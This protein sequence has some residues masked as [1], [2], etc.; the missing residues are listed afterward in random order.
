MGKYLDYN[1][2][3]YLWRKIKAFFVS[4]IGVSGNDLTYTKNG[5]TNNITIPYAT[6]AGALAILQSKT[7][8]NV[9]GTADNNPGSVFYFL[10]VKPTDW[11]LP[12]IVTYRIS[13]KIGGV[14]SGTAVSILKVAFTRNTM[15][16]YGVW[17]YIG[18]TNYR[19]YYYHYRYL[20]TATGFNAG[21]GHLLGIGLNSSYKPTTAANARTFDVEVLEIS[22][23]TFTLF[24]SMTKYANV[25]GTGSTNYSGETTLNATTQG[26]THSGDATATNYLHSTG[27]VGPVGPIGILSGSLFMQTGTGHW[28][29]FTTNNSASTSSNKQKNTEGFKLESPVL[30][31]TGTNNAPNA[32]NTNV[33]IYLS[34][35]VDLRYSTNCGATL[36]LHRPVYL[37]GTI[38]SDGLFYLDDTWWTQTLPSSDDGKVYI[39]LGQ[40]YGSYTIQL[41]PMHPIYYFKNGKVRQYLVEQET[42]P[43]FSASP[44]AG[45]TSADITSWNGK[46]DTITDL[47]TIRSGA[48]AG[49]TAYQ[50]PSGGIPKSDLSSAVQTSL[51]KADTALQSHQDISGKVDKVTSTDNA[52]VRFNGTSG[53]IQNSGV[54]IDDNNNVT[55]AKFV[56]KNGTN[57]QFVKGDGSLSDYIFQLN[58]SFEA[59]KQMLYISPLQNALWAADKRFVVTCVDI[60]GNG[61]ETPITSNLNELFNFNYEDNSNRIAAGHTYKIT[62]SHSSPDSAYMF[63]YSSGAFIVNFYYTQIPQSVSLRLYYGEIGNI[64]W[65]NSIAVD[66]ITGISSGTYKCWISEQYNYVRKIEI[67]IVARANGATWPN[68]LEYFQR[69][70]TGAASMPLVTK[71]SSNTLL[72]NLTAPKFIKTGGTSSQFLKADGSVDSNTY[73]KTSDI[74]AWAK[75]S[76]KPS[77]TWNEINDKPSTFTPS[78]HTHT[79]SIATST[80]TNQITLAHGSKYSITAGGTSYIFTMPAS[81]NTDRYVNSAAFA[82]DSTNTA[83]SPVKMTLTRAGSDTATVTANIPK[84]SS[85]SA[86]VAPKGAAVSSQSQSTK[87]LREDGTWAAPSYTTNTNTT[88]SFTGGTNGRFSVTPSGSNTQTVAVTKSFG[89]SIEYIVGTQTAATNLWIGVTQEASLSAGKMIAYKLPVAGNGSAATLNLTLSGGGTTGAIGVRRKGTGTVTT[90]YSAGEIIFMVYDGSYWQIN[91]YYDSDSTGYYTK[92]IYPN[93]KAGPGKI[94]PYTMIMQLPDGRWESLV[95]SNST[96]TSKVA[97]THGFLLG[98]VLLM[99]ANAT[100]TE[101]QNVGTYYIWSFH[102]GLIDHRYSFNT[103]NDSTNGTTGYKPIYIVGSIGSDGLF[104]LDTTKWWTQTLPSTEDGKLY[105]YIGDAYD[106][107]RM[108]FTED[109]PI[110]LYSNGGIKLY[111]GTSDNVSWSNVTSK[112]SLDG[113]PDGST[114][115]LSDYVTL[116]TAQTISGIKTFSSGFKLNAGSSWTSSD[117]TIP[118]SASGAPLQI[119]YTNDNANTGLTYNPSTGALKA[120]SFVKRSGTS[121]QFLKADGSVDSTDYAPKASPALT[122][123]PTAPTAVANTNTTQI[124]TTA[125]V[126]TAIDNLPTPMVFQGTIGTSG[127]SATVP[128]NPTEGDTYKIIEGGTSLTFSGISGTIKVGDTVIYKNSTVGWILIPSGDEPSGTVTSITLKATSPI[129]I[130]ST[131]A[132]TTSGTRTFSHS[133]SGVTAGTYESVTV[134]ATGHVTAGTNPTKYWANVQV[135]SSTNY[136]TEPELKSVKINGSTTNSASTANALLQY[137]TTNKCLNFI[138]T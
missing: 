68:E 112:P 94:F 7:Y 66:T 41:W 72:Y 62:I 24:D 138:V 29:P 37:V 101:N 89:D 19:P 121:S 35:P 67:T 50:K 69:R 56:T 110:Y 12:C 116:T 55:A 108:T 20:A 128:S 84:V 90:H 99:Y 83:A 13:A 118:F 42:D 3:A 125:F 122:G 114:R 15:T 92:R 16:A 77:Y 44:A 70:M 87:F 21:Y 23:G 53:A 22:N 129:A 57:S 120:A 85:S 4:S 28:S 115:K 59:E 47:A 95:T 30:Y 82:D 26:D 93:L 52:V 17:N 98:H 5:T 86:G 124:A 39:Y 109:K 14:S 80:G 40:A 58:N 65:S 136:N 117:R 36:V 63:L 79:T 137:D 54:T 133:N 49:A 88:Y 75:E 46:Q 25:P 119:Q 123:T 106:Y 96:G 100:Y 6:Q 134:N 71:F 27:C 18:D 111:G 104:Y 105:I 8:T 97:N 45:I 11:N 113:I 74:S 48:S 76:T 107:Y 131:A 127:T 9:I 43:V 33:T 32:V 73:L 1:G 135:G 103:A 51:G 102:S 64:K 10:S 2:L 130:D 34:T 60:D 31:F 38:G 132:I 126:K 81:G 91:S 61:N 78:S